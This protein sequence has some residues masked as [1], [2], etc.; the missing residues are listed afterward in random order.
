M[1][2]RETFEDRW[3]NEQQTNQQPPEN[4]EREYMI[5]LCGW[6]DGVKNYIS[7]ISRQRPTTS[8]S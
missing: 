8:S 6:E 5:Y 7:Q 3:Q 1:T 2:A 4:K